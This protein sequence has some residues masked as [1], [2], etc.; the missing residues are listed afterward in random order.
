MRYS[1]TKR[2]AVLVAFLLALSLPMQHAACQ[3]S[4]KNESA[5]VPN[6]ILINIDD[7][8][9]DLVS[10]QRLTHYP[11]LKQLAN[12][13]V[14]FG[15]CHVTT[16]L[17]GPS[18]ACLYRSQYAH[19]TG[20]RTNRANLDVGSGFTGGTQYFQDSGLSAD[21]LPVWMQRAGYHTMLVGKYFQGE[22]EFIPVP[23]WDRF[24]DWGGNRYY[25]AERFDIYPDGKR[26]NR[27][28]RG[29]RTELETNDVLELLD[30]YA[31]DVARDKPF[32]LYVAPVAPHVGPQKKEVRIP[33]RWKDR[34]PDAQLPVSANINEADV[35][36]KPVAYSDRLPFTDAQ[37]ESM[38][39][40][41]RRRL[42]A[43]LGVD[44]MVKRIRKKVSDIGQA[45]NTVVIFT[46]DH[47]YL[48]GHHRIQGKSFPLVEATRVPLWVHWPE[49]IKARDA[50]QLLA[51]IDISATVADIG[52]ATLPD[53]VDGRSFRKVLLDESIVEPDAVR[54]SVLIENW[55]S[56]LNSASKQ[57]IVYSSILK[58]GSIYTQ[59][60][61]GEHEFYDLKADPQQL[62][63]GYEALD[64]VTQSLLEAELH[65]LRQNVSRYFGTMVTLSF[66]T[67]N[68]RFIGPDIELQ[69]FAES[70][71]G[72]SQVNISI[73]R[74]KTGQYWSGS[75]W[76][77]E[78][79]RIPTESPI[80][81][82]LLH[83]WRVEPEIA[84]LEAGEKLTIEVYAED[85]ISPNASTRKLDV[86]FDN[87][88]PETVV[89]R[90]LD[91]YIYPEFSNFGG[92]ISDDHFPGDVRLFIFNLDTRKYLDGEQ[93]VTGKKSVSV[94]INRQRGLWHARHS[95]P[96][97]RY[98]ITAIGKDAAGNWSQPSKPNRCVI[99]RSCEE[100][101]KLDEPIR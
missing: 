90:P 16:P 69:G 19:N 73:R 45:K 77:N 85:L 4:A 75:S 26:K 84:E 59:W 66:P 6:I 35:S 22:T 9:V 42:I 39:V 87:M 21:Q 95:L 37:L 53:F 101:G 97:G 76:K 49:K 71:S 17:C 56:R 63:N 12:S 40:V 93:W 61:T 36:D 11:N 72:K 68:R 30:Q 2:L 32:F 25:D 74:K 91:Q 88:P 60:A 3:E 98:E 27:T 64:G 20:F 67:V 81:A 65:S 62:D 52:A 80:G 34:F 8:D 94:L 13:S 7:C 28:G 57:K 79:V 54:Q 10:E 78:M 47:G 29:Y 89:V 38:R 33:D 83:A 58:P 96:D 14:R 50:D 99:D 5:R 23:G 48:L 100:P 1:N 46:S 18:R 82:G 55:E 70:T 24:V 41:Q 51:H 86:T 92:K 44:E 31:T 15:N 43:M